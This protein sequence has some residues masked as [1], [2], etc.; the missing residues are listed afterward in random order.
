MMKELYS[1]LVD[2]KIGKKKEKVKVGLLKP[3]KSMIEDGDFFYASEYNRF[4]NAG[5]L[6]RAMM[7]KKMGDLGGIASQKDLEDLQ[8]T[9]LSLVDSQKVIE[10]YGGAEELTEEQEE[11]LKEAQLTFANCQAHL[12]EHQMSV[13]NQ[14]SQTA[15]NKA[16]ERLLKW[17]VFNH[18]IFYDKV[19]EKE[20][21]FDLFE[22]N[23]FKEKEEFY[24]MIIDEDFDEEDK[25]TAKKKELI[26]SSLDRLLQA[27][28]IWYNNLGDNQKDI[29]AKIKEIFGDSK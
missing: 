17:Y 6:T 9:I 10:F 29:D 21:Y 12:A 28:S 11:K 1:F 7:N 23:T 15:D 14:Y 20:E 24:K 8:E 16:Q 13:D 25:E 5:L 3:R 27:I 26:D 19:G 22:G 4:V 18:A 2:R